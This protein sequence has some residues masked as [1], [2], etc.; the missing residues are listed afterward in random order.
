MTVHIL[1]NLKLKM[2]LE[3]HLVKI[4]W[5]KK[6]FDDI[7][8]VSFEFPGGG[9][10]LWFVKALSTGGFEPI[11]CSMYQSLETMAIRMKEEMMKGC[12]C[13]VGGS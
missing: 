6:I 9:Y 8:E 3:G 13:E 5:A 11:C 10:Q 1:T 7:Y 2:I 12:N 4:I